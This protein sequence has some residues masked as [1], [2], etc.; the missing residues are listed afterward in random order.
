MGILEILKTDAVPDALG[1]GEFLV[2]ISEDLSTKF[3][4]APATLN[5]GFV[6]E[7]P[8][9]FRPVIDNWLSRSST[10]NTAQSKP[11]RDEFGEPGFAASVADYPIDAIRFPADWTASPDFETVFR[12]QSPEVSLLPLAK[13]AAPIESTSYLT[14]LFLG[15]GRLGGNFVTDLDET[16][17]IG[18]HV[19]TQGGLG[20]GIDA[21]VN[22]WQR[23][24]A[25]LGR[26]PLWTGDLNMMYSL[27]PISRFKLRSGVGGSWLVDDGE[28]KYGY[29]FTHGIDIYLLWRGMFTGEIDW[30]EIDGDSL[31]RYRFGL[32]LTVKSFDIFT[33]Y[34]SQKIGNERL[35]GWMNGVAIWY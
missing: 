12:G 6:T 23:P 3:A 16:E 13:G 8:G 20:A 27:S 26:E 32:G 34:E 19:L 9:E 33:G 22:Y 14:P 2:S 30:G 10:R 28:A 7:S 29:N 11:W 1:D 31:F 4:P 24:V 35:D 17:K 5:V 15:N 18:V 21:E 25:G